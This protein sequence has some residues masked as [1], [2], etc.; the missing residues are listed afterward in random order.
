MINNLEEKK[1]I[2]NRIRKLENILFDLKEKLL[3]DREDQYNAMA[4]VYVKKII[5]LREEIEEYIGMNNILIEKSDINIHINGPAIGYGNAPISIISSY[6]D[7]LKSSVRRNYG[8]L[9]NRSKVP[10]NIALL[11]DFTLN[12]LAAGSINISLSIP[13][14]QMSFLDHTSLDRSLKIYFELLQ[15]V[16]M[17]DEELAIDGVDDESMGKL[18][19]NILKIV[20]DDKNIR[21]IEVYG[22]KVL[23]QSKI[24]LDHQSRRF[25]LG[26]IENI[27]KK[28]KNVS[29]EGIIRELD[30]DKLTF[31]LRDIN[32]A[33]KEQIKCSV[34]KEETED[35]GIYLNSYVKV[36]GILEG[37]L[38]KV[39]YI[40]KINK[41]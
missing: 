23:H 19:S 6:L 7:N 35:L 12:Q 8:I 4:Y 37:N 36:T 21:N 30:L 39:K 32:Y 16:S 28:E 13:N 17:R 20:P 10:Q 38:L 18:L 31:C 25:I 3:P 9:Y 33:G 5:E 26:K 29:I 2:E 34:P 24:C 22:E 11:T 40:D 1:F 15:L 41:N 14:E 27:N